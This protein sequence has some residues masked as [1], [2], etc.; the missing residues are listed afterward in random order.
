M[1][2]AVAD[3]NRRALLDALVSGETA[4]GDLAKA[5]GL[6]YSAVSQHLAILRAARLVES[7]KDG[8]YQWYQLDA[9]PLRDVHTWASHYERFWRHRLR[10]LKTVVE[11][12]T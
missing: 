9:T 4:V 12:A 1:F 11:T 3:A 7:R 5:A 10:R 2:H 6:S 8:R